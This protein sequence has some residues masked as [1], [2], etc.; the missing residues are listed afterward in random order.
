MRA[1]GPHLRHQPGRGLHPPSSRRHS[2]RC[3]LYL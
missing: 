1:A 2:S 3:P